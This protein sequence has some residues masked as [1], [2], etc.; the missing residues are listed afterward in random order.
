MNFF[1]NSPD[2][3]K[4][5]FWKKKTNWD[6]VAPSSP[7][8]IRI[9]VAALN[10]YRNLVVM[11]SEPASKD[12]QTK[13]DALS[14][15]VQHVEQDD[16]DFEK[17]ANELESTVKAF[18]DRQQKS[19]ERSL[20]AVYDGMRD[21][22]LSLDGAVNSSESLESAATGTQERLEELKRTQNYE[23]LVRGISAEVASLAKAIERHKADAKL[24]RKVC[25]KQIEDLRTKV[26][27]AERAV[28]TDYLTKLHNRA[29][30]DFLLNA[31]ISR[32][33]IGEAACLAILDLN[34]FK[35]INDRY[36]HLAGDAALVEFAGKIMETFGAN[37]AQVARIGGDEFAVIFKGNEI[38]C[39]AKLERLSDTL[40]KKPLMYLEHEISLSASY[41]LLPLEAH[42]TSESAFQH[43]DQNM[44]KQ[45][46]AA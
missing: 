8:A 18:S 22:W 38:S 1:R 29:S 40:A 39:R 41:G 35:Q 13:I 12:F 28:K 26:R 36:G 9:G 34:K 15:D 6:E 3:S 14:Q 24:I 21:V 11:P 25:S 32:T 44:Y 10:G 2:N 17:I 7:S 46:R 4:D 31:A 43:A 5:M 30:F 45:K 19:L 16:H 27:H 23:A 20:E 37:S 42:F 33:S